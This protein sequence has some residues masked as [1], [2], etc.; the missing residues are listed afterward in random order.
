MTD[1]TISTVANSS[2]A[3]KRKEIYLPDTRG[4]KPVWR[5][6][7]TPKPHKGDCRQPIARYNAALR[8]ITPYREQR[9]EFPA[10]AKTEYKTESK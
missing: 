7:M 8:D 1:N 6:R 9:K 2:P 5:G 10:V 3:A 4:N